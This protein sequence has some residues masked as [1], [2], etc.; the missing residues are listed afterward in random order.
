MPGFWDHRAMSHDDKIATDL[1]AAGAGIE[2]TIEELHE[3]G[4]GPMPIA[5]AMLGGALGLLA[6]VMDDNAIL[7]VLHSAATGVASGELRRSLKEG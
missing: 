1:A 7:N 4:L 3:R 6:Q 5:S 2:K